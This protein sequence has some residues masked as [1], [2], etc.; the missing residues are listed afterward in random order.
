MK[1][2]E[3]E[4]K[5]ALR[6]QADSFDMQVEPPHHIVAAIHRRRSR[7]GVLIGLGS[8]TLVAIV[9]ASVFVSQVTGSGTPAGSGR[10]GT[11]TNG[12]AAMS[13]VLLDSKVATGEETSAP[14]WL[15]DHIACMRNQGFNI[16]DPTQTSDGWS[17]I[18]DDP[19]AAGLGTSAWREAAFVTCAIDRPLSG[20]LILGISKDK[21]DAFVGC[22]AGQGYHLPAPTVNQDGEYE[23]DL[24]A[25]TIDT[26]RAA[27]DRA[28]FVTCSPEAD[29]GG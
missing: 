8:A 29:A 14:R 15:S 2:S 27:W 6:R 3:S 17:I 12:V 4:I 16:P 28:V 1:T 11:T 24:T 20:N 21:V 23:F 18:V 13:Y 19:A 9:A 10:A 7:N 26:G 25:S 22:M 5:E